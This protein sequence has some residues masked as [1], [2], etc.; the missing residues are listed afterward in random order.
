[1][2]KFAVKADFYFFTRWKIMKDL[3]FYRRCRI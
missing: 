1:M 3:F 2:I